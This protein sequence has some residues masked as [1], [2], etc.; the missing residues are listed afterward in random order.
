MGVP[1]LRLCSSV[2]NDASTTLSTSIFLCE[3]YRQ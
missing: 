2:E 1:T 3:R